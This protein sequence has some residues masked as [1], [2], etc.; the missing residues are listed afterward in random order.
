MIKKLEIALI[1]LIGVILL[2]SLYSFTGLTHISY[3]P[4][5]IVI[6]GITG[7]YTFIRFNA[8]KFF[9]LINNWNVAFFFIASSFLMVVPIVANGAEIKINDLVRVVSFCLFFS[10]TFFLY[11]DA[12]SMKKFLFNI[13]LITIIILFLEGLLYLTQPLLMTF[14]LDKEPVKLNEIKSSL[15]DRNS[16]SN[17]LVFLLAIILQTLPEMKKVTKAIFLILL[18]GVTIFFVEESG[19]RAALL[20][21]FLLF[22]INVSSKITKKGLVYIALG[23]II[24]S[25]LLLISLPAL[26]EYSIQNPTSSISRLFFTDSNPKSIASN[27]ERANSIYAG[28]EFILHNYVIFGPGSFAFESEW[29]AFNSSDSHFPHNVFIFIWC[30]YGLFSIAYFYFLDIAFKRGLKAKLYSL[31]AIYSIQ[32]IFSPNAFYYVYA[33]LVMF[34]IDINFFLLNPPNKAEEISTTSK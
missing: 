24:S 25:I 31:L 27:I 22:I 12:E 8:L 17:A 3:I 4:F 5:F 9:N 19:S 2:A 15:G 11:S 6:L 26:K 7:F 21:L 14:L 32:F 18:I 23:L 30:Q 28:I 10:W 34:I 16:Y 1:Y 20:M 13:C 29:W 33:F